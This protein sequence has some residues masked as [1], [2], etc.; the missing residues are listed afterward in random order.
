MFLALKKNGAIKKASKPELKHKSVQFTVMLC[1]RR[2]KQKS[3]TQCRIQDKTKHHWMHSLPSKLSVTENVSQHFKH[4]CHRDVIS[5]Q[6]NLVHSSFAWKKKE[7]G[8]E[9]KEN[10][11]EIHQNPKNIVYNIFI[12]SI[13]EFVQ[14]K[15]IHSAICQCS[16]RRNFP[17]RKFTI[18]P[19]SIYLLIGFINNLFGQNLYWLSTREFEISGGSLVTNNSSFF[20]GFTRAG[21]ISSHAT[22]IYT[23]QRRLCFKYPTRRFLSQHSNV[24]DFR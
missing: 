1:S 18:K 20:G 24:Y 2:Q 5:V 17:T 23:Q 9:V 16:F 11:R 19:R 4:T 7:A 6:S 10:Q 3:S 13:L 21:K 15:I 22:C 8:N 14:L 12:E